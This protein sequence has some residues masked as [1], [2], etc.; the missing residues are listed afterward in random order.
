MAISHYRPLPGESFSSIDF[1]LPII[2]LPSLGTLRINDVTLHPSPS[3]LGQ[4]LLITTEEGDIQIS[5]M[6]DFKPIADILDLL[7]NNLEITLTRCAMGHP[8]G[9]FNT[10]GY[11]TLRDIEANEDLVP[12][13]RC[14]QGE[15]LF[16][17]NCAGLNDAVL[18]LMATVEAEGYTCAP[19]MAELSI[20]NCPNFSAAA[21][22]RLVDA[23]LQVF[24]ERVFPGMNL[25]HI[26][27][28]AP[29]IS[30]EDQRHMAQYAYR[31]EYNPS[32]A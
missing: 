19:R 18:D 17:N 29:D 16:F 23:R 28:L 24:E 31:F 27:G 10:D 9:P 30:T 7:P 4:T 21:L 22:R 13:L 2:A 15:E 11:L 8:R 26:S 5:H 32:S 25:L 12:L 1:I 6:H 3:T 14:W 20:E